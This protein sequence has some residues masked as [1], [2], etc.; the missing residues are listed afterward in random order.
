[1]KRVSVVGST[2]SGKTTFARRLA[3]ILG[4]DFVELDAL[5]WE[6]NWAMADEHE[7]QARIKSATNADGWV[8]D[9]NYGGRGA[10]E[11]VWGRADTV[12]WLDMPLWLILARL[13]RRNL[14]RIRSGV[15][16]WPGTGNRETVR[17]SFFST[18]S[19]YVWALK[20]YRRRKRQMPE[21]L[22]RPEYA[23]LERHHFTRAA[24]AERWLEAQRRLAA[25]R[26]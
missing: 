2:G 11:I 12:V 1:V 14:T 18:D 16:I 6:A 13:T 8:V 15:E 19:L 26:I 10:R 23:H 17:N 5:N 20:T 9:G 22:A 3:Q 7:F 24:D 4:V 25:P 21:L